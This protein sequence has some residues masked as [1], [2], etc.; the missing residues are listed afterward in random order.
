M[1]ENAPIRTKLYK[2]ICSDQPDVD[3]Y[4]RA[5]RI[6]HNCSN[7]SDDHKDKMRLE[8]LFSDITLKLE[9]YI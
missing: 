7:Y 1:Y 6:Y 9:K 4:T 3:R 8:H 5:C 2:I